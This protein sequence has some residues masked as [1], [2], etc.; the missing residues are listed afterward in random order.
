MTTTRKS[1]YIAIAAAACVSLGAAAPLATAD[2]PAGLPHGPQATTTES[3]D[4]APAKQPTQAE[5]KRGYGV[6]C[7][8][9]SKRHVEG[10][11]GTPFSQC[12]VALAKIDSGKADSPK[13]AC[14]ALSKKHVKGQKGTPFSQC[15][16]AAAQQAKRTAQ[17]S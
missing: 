3:P 11:K 17:A 12:V 4:A 7:K 15:V 14:K 13:A 10:Q 8:G 1:T 2:Q 9:L 6:L 16:K 5:R